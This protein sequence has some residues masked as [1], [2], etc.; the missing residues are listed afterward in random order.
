MSNFFFKKMINKCFGLNINFR[1]S[2]IK[3]IG[4]NNRKCPTFLKKKIHIKSFFFSKRNLTIDKQLERNIKDN[5]LLLKANKNF[6]GIRHTLNL[7][8]R[9]QRTH[10]NA[11]TKKKLKN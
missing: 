8:T 4:L 1:Y 9:G 2:F 5:I 3:N 11:K 10:T 6:R 7:P